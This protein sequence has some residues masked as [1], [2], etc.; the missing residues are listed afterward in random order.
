MIMTFEDYLR[1]ARSTTQAEVDHR[2]AMHD[3]NDLSPAERKT[4][5]SGPIP[6]ITR[7]VQ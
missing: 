4:Y 6:K 1:S 2:T 7:R 3:Q 5:E